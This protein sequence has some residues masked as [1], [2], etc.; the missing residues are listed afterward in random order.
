MAR[1][2][3]FDGDSSYAAFTRVTYKLLMRGEWVTYAD[4]MAAAS[5]RELKCSVSKCD[6]YGE[7]KKAVPDVLRA[8]KERCGD[9]CIETDGN[10]RTRRLKYIGKDISPLEDLINARAISS[11]R[12]YWKFCQDSAGFLPASWL[13]YFFKD[14]QDLLD[15]KTKRQRG[16]QV[17][18]SSVDR[19]LK[20]IDLLPQLYEAIVNRKVLEFEFKPFDEDQVTLT[21]HPHYLKEYNGRWHMMGHA[22]GREPELGFNVPIDRIQS[23]PRIKDDLPYIPA[24]KLYYQGFFENIVGVSHETNAEVKNII[25]RAHTNY[26]FNLIKTKPIHGSQV[27]VK[28]FGKHDDGEYGEFELTIEVNNEFMGR[29]LQMGDGLEVMSPPEVRQRFANRVKNMMGMYK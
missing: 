5:G 8:L 24:T 15:I 1:K 4:V 25:V 3:I 17:I 29:V 23:K 26:M 10:N 13:E 19:Q 16:E 21:F 11:L 14:C 18:S 12:E 22:E 6:D 27:V 7:L 2:N 20:N 28:P 9:D